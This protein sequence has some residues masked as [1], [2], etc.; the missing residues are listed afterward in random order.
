MKSGFYWAFIGPDGGKSG[1]FLIQEEHPR[2]LS[3]IENASGI[4]IIARF[5]LTKTTL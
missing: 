4:M 3:L 5:V 2:H 1:T